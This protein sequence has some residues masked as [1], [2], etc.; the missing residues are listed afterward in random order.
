MKGIAFTAYD[1]FAYLSSGFF[2]IG[3]ADYAFPGTW[4]IDAR[5]NTGHVFLWIVVAYVLG[6]M[7]AQISATV[8]EKGLVKHVLGYPTTVLFRGPEERNKPT[9]RKRLAWI[10][11]QQEW[12]RKNVRLLFPGYSEPLP[13]Q[14]CS[15]VRETVKKDGLNI[16]EDPALFMYCDARVKTNDQTGALLTVFLSLY[17]FARNVCVSAALAAVLL[18][19]GAVLYHENWDTKLWLSGV[20]AVMAVFLLYRYL[21]FF[22]VYALELFSAYAALYPVSDS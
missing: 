15:L 17:G 19:G 12:S 1:V 5:L 4:L 11:N 8:L 9:W 13:L 18:L 2:L 21:K 10:F 16:T 22:R 20:A 7:V 14:M 3:A 6:H